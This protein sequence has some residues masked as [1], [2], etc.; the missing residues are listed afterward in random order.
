L[1]AKDSTGHHD[2]LAGCRLAASLLAQTASVSVATV[3][4]GWP[5]NDG[6]FDG[7]RSLVF[8]AA[9]ADKHP[10]SRRPTDRNDAAFESTTASASS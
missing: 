10:S 3:H 8:Y 1:K 9:G 5:E 7:A 4:D 6:V 2:Y